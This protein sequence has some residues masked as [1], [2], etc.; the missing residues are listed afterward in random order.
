MA[1]VK[2]IN[3]SVDKHLKVFNV[4]MDL[5]FPNHKTDTRAKDK[6]EAR[7]KPEKKRD[8]DN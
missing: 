5:F 3:Y 4:A 1:Q 2:D 8:D 7:Q 6:Q